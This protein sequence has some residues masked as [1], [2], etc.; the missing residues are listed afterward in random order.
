[1]TADNTQTAGRLLPAFSMPF[2]LD[3]PY[4]VKNWLRRGQ[5]SMIYGPSNVGKS[6][7][8]IDLV[9]SITTGEDWNG[10][11]VK[12]GKVLYIA[13]EGHSGLGQRLEA[14]KVLRGVPPNYS[15]DQ[16]R[17]LPEKIDLYAS[18]GLQEV[19]ELLGVHS[20]DLIIIDTLAMALGS[21]SEN[22][23]TTIN[24]FL[25]NLSEL[26]GLSD[27]HIMLI[28]HTGKDH[29]RGAR[30]HSSLQAAVDTEISLKSEDGLV[31][32]STTKQRD[33][34]RADKLYFYL[35]SVVLGVDADGDDV[36]SCVVRYT[37]KGDR[38]KK[39]TKAKQSVLDGLEEAL[40]RF[41]TIHKGNADIPPNTRVVDGFAWKD[42]VLSDTKLSPDAKDD[43]RRRAFS[44]IAKE[45]LNEKLM[46]TDG[47]DLFW[48]SEKTE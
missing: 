40:D 16:W 21:G 17:V 41:G 43:S 48:L 20:F 44:R 32:V 47:S 27:V 10:Y 5:T 29:E 24:A 1:M 33:Y 30:G 13:T 2:S 15:D 9:Y 12:Q 4:L 35:E 25:R 22:D 28:H 23:N 7:F 3:A 39:L 34:Q 42:I 37:S 8:V 11:R 18:E 38:P 26:R 6:F 45:L 19:R 31:C 14:L 46:Y 36:T